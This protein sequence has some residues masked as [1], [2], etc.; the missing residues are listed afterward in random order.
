MLGLADA[1]RLTA[2]GLGAMIAAVI[3]LAPPP[4]ARA[5]STELAMFSDD[6][7][8]YTNP[9]G[10]LQTLRDLGV[11]EV[12]L[13][14]RWQQLAPRPNAARP[15][16]G[17]D[18][19]NPAAYP[20]RSW[21]ALDRAVTDTAP[22]GSGIDL[23]TVGGAPAGA[24]GPG[25]PHGDLNSSWEPI[26]KDYGEFV[27]AV[28]TRYSGNYDPAT[29][30]LDPGNP[31]D[32]PRISFW[33]VW[34]EPDYGPSLAPQG[35][36]GD[37]TVPHAPEMYRQ[38]VDAAWTALHRTGHRAD[39]FVIGEIAPRGKNSWGVFSGMK[40]LTFI[41]NMYCVSA[42][43]RELRG[44][45]AALR[46][47]PTTAAGSARFRADNPGLFAA[48]GFS[49]HPYSRYF[50]PNVE[51]NNDPQYTS[52]ADIGNLT[53]A[54][55]HVNR[56][57]GSSE[58]FPIYN[59]EYG[60]ITSPPKISP[61]HSSKPPEYYVS[62]ATA[63]AYLNQAEYMSWRNP[64]IQ[65]FMQYLLQDPEPRTKATD[66]GG[67]ASGLETFSGKPKATY[68]AWRLP[69][70][71][72][73]TA[74]KLGASLQV[75]G[76]V[77]PAHYALLDDP[78]EPES[79]TVEFEPTGAPS[80]STIDTVPLTSPQGYFDTQVAF[81]SSGTVRLMWTYPSDDMML[82]PGTVAYSRSVQITIH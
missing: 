67:Y 76:D 27:R 52:L 10:T 22:T 43:Y 72:P 79:V 26:A 42:Q 68:Y 60:Y 41:R 54:L 78:S 23:D 16:S 63:A 64:R 58:H 35:L 55:D 45:T 47:C 70:Y 48:S 62:P 19:A 12:R 5:S 65:S 2:F 29:N 33:S 11:G 37:L 15:P 49:D 40:P 1:R 61:D 73:V 74:A 77:R 44:R 59:T 56:V 69:L 82:L 6:G 75:W 53:G 20:A 14:V 7:G 71:L 36:P 3:V 51:E 28:A 80:F 81:I 38:L 17:F 4:P 18:A 21:T 25:Q 8:L 39:T 30:S 9:V 50:P 13:S 32:L 34:N 66:Y 24:R 31:A 57:Y 46:G